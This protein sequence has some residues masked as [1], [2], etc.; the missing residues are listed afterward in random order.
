M[1]P[2][3][4]FS[5]PPDAARPLEGA[6]PGRAQDPQP[7]E[8]FDAFMG[9]ALARS[10]RKASD[11][12]E[13]PDERRRGKDR[14]NQTHKSDSTHPA[15]PDPPV[16]AENLVARASL[17]TAP[18]APATE[19]SKPQPENAAWLAPRWMRIT[20]LSQQPAWP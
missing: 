4:I 11:D 6:C 3:E 17:P 10:P 5:P 12:S 1:Q 13:S 7:A 20:A 9:Y 14:A 18:A 16:C 15:R 8:P 19:G 2:V